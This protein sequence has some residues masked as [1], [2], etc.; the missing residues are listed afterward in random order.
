MEGKRAVIELLGT[1]I[2][3]QTDEDAAYLSRIVQ[4]LEQK[5][6]GVEKSM[7]LK[8]PLKASILASVILVDELFKERNRS[9]EGSSVQDAV[10]AEHIALRIIE[11]I[12]K[13]LINGTPAP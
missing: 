9:V 11:K 5:I 3:V 6:E 12:E 4:Y 8:D 10:E 7:P 13:T 1:T 2:H